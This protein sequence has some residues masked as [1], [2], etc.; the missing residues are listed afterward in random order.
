MHI[1]AT[2]NGQLS[3]GVTEKEYGSKAQ[4]I[5]FFAYSLSW[6]AVS[7]TEQHDLLRSGMRWIEMLWLVCKAGR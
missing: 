5:I 1:A 3:L 2:S 6:P 7:A 4:S